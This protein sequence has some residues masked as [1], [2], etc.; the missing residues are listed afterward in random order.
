M[1]RV[2]MLGLMRRCVSWLPE[3]HLFDVKARLY[4]MAGLQINSSA[5]VYS[6]VVFS[7]YPVII[8]ARTH[9]GAFC[10]FTG[11]TGCPIEIGSDCDIAPYVTF[12]TGTH[13]IGSKI[14]RA[15]QE[16]AL[17]VKVG[18]GTWIG[19]RSILLP[20]VTIGQ[21]SVIAAGSVVTCDI[22]S[23]SLAAGVPALIKSQLHI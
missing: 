6:S 2:Y 22:P 1:M 16:K 4:N 18:N 15:G 8:G 11:A 12:L 21:G 14:R 17:P 7:T 3:S 10:V 20:G 13:D 19:A 23:N 5:H 9:V